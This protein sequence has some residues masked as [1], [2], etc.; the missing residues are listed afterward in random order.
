[1][2]W[3]AGAP[4]ELLPR[5]RHYDA[6]AATFQTN[7]RAGR[8]GIY[9][10]YLTYSHDAAATLPSHTSRAIRCNARGQEA[11]ARRTLRDILA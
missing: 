5:H 7:G 1:M 4:S 11:A 8:Q 10:F 2:R 3:R 6:A 9:T